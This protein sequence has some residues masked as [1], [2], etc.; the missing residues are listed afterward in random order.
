MKMQ[1]RWLGRI[2]EHL[3]SVLDLSD[4]TSLRLRKQ[5]RIYYLN[6]KNDKNMRIS[7]MLTLLFVLPLNNNIINL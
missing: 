2:W 5:G 6:S 7:N 3:K 1:R 4:V